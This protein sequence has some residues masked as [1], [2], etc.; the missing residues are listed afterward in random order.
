M[1]TKRLN[2][3][4]TRCGEPLR[5]ING[6]IAPPRPPVSIM[7]A[8]TSKTGSQEL[9]GVVQAARLKV[10]TA[11]NRWKTA[12][13]QA[14]AAKRRRRAVRLIA[15]RAKKQ[16]KQAKADLAEARIALAEAEAKFAESGARLTTRI[17]AR[18]VAKVTSARRKTAARALKGQPVPL[19]PSPVSQITPALDAAQP[20]TSDP[21]LAEAK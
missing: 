12:R 9:A 3:N 18:P 10:A 8:S 15:R 4:N 2:R 13:E 19:A 17:K 11:E 20:G 14:R 5:L 6:A 16:A 21:A 7:K 1:K